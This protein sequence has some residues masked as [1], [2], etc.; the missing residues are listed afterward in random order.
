MSYNNPPDK[1]TVG[2][3][4]KVNKVFDFLS[5][6][7]DRWTHRREIAEVL[8]VKPGNI[9]D[10]VIRDLRMTL[11]AGDTIT[12]VANPDGGGYRLVGTYDEAR[13]WATGRVTDAET[14]LESIQYG[15][16]PIVRAT[17]GRTVEGRKARLIEMTTRHLVE[18]LA[19]ISVEDI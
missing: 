16:A 14:R 13:A 3:I 7:L 11:G 17:D 15:M 6:N 1:W 4:E 12:V 5:N 19:A 2:R 18:Q 8:D 10:R 9:V